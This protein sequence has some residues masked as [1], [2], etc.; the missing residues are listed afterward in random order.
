M[1]KFTRFVVEKTTLEYHPELNQKLWDGVELRTDVRTQLLKL[2]KEWQRFANIPNSA[3]KDI[4]FTGGNANYNYTSTSDIDIHIVIDKNSIYSDRKL[5]DD[6]YKDKKALW[7]LTHEVRVKGY[8]IEFYAQGLDE[9]LVAS[10][11][12]SL[13]S[14]EWIKK[15]IHGDYDFES[16]GLEKK[17]DSYR[18]MIDS[19]ID[20]KADKA[21]FKLLKDK[22]RDLRKSSLSSGGEFAEGNL[23][24]KSLRNE[25][26][27]DKMS[28]Y[29]RK[30]EDEALS[31]D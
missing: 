16:E 17:V 8:P 24:F 19:L 28:K 18:Q 2:A 25:G 31:M 4:I 12:Y 21:A 22:L 7:S 11:I 14:G 20:S 1:L 6:Y 23:V 13:K 30:K 3:V 9:T 10:A 26:Y 29:L 27:L 5:V 15:P